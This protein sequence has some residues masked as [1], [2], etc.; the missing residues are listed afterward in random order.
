MCEG[1]L[2]NSK[3]EWHNSRIPRI[4][5]EEGEKQIEDVESG[6]GKK[7]EKS[8]QKLRVE[9]IERGRNDK[10]GMEREVEGSEGQVERK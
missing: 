6:L 9:D 4:I 7:S 2:L 10:R 1:V 8:K 5:V 3:S